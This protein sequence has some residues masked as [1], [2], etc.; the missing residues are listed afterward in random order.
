MGLTPAGQLDKRISLERAGLIRSAAGPS[1]VGSWEALGSRWAKVTY[2][3]SA[4]RREAGSERAVQVATFRCRADSL[5][6]TIM[7][8]DRIVHA[9]ASWDV[10][11]IAP[12]G[13]GPAELEFTAT[14]ARG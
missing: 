14:A 12:I 3:S 11:G 1:K 4:E 9:G 6:R 13:R 8:T 2:G 7:V 10:T 5:T